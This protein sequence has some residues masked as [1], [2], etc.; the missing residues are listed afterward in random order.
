[1]FEKEYENQFKD[2]SDED[3]EEKEKEI[4][5][6]LS[7]LPIHHVIRQLKIS[8]LF[9]DFHCVSVYPRAMWDKSI[10]YPRI[11]TG[12]AYTKDLNSDLVKKFNNQN[13]Y[14]RICYIEI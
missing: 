9:W 13:I 8:E 14:S 10:I 2:Y 11:E 7:E 4:N 6:K 1:M 3:V 12:L 5:E